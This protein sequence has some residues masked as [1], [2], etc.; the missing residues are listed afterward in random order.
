L[1]SGEWYDASVP[2]FEGRIADP[3]AVATLG[4]TFPIVGDLW[5][6]VSEGVALHY[7]RLAG[8][9]LEPDLRVSKNR[10][11]AVLTSGLSLELA[12]GATR[13]VASASGAYWT[14]WQA[15]VIRDD[16]TISMG[17]FSGEVSAAV[18]VLL[19]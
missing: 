5:L 7:V 18:R 19:Q 15:F 3:A 12:L 2:G 11:D 17:P 16:T 6:G 13:L 9:L 8:T 1:E 10:F 4:A 14:Q